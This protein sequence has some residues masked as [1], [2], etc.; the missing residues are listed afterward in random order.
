MKWRQIIKTDKGPEER[1]RTAKG[2]VGRRGWR[3]AGAVRS[4][5]AQPLLPVPPLLLRLADLFLPPMFGFPAPPPHVLSS[6]VKSCPALS[7]PPAHIPFLF[8]GPGGGPLGGR[9]RVPWHQG[10]S[11]FQ[12]RCLG[13]SGSVH[14]QNVGWESGD[15]GSRTTW[16]QL[17]SHS[18]SLG[19]SLYFCDMMG[20]DSDI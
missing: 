9:L 3:W 2:G 4:P 8:R 18:L 20:S 1:Q 5:A 11:K 15:L 17:Q 12:K 7:S 16:L 19:L 10:R 6:S 13:R 14:K